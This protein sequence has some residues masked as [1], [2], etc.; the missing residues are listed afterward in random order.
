M[1]HMPMVAELLLEGEGNTGQ[2]QVDMQNIPLW[3]PSELPLDTR[4]ECQ[5]GLSEMEEVLH[6]A[7]CHD[8]LAQ[9]RAI[10]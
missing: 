10:E 9:L 4:K 5:K 2:Q 7:R 8:K 3:L 1:R 6:V